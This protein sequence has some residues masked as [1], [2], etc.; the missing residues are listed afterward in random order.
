MI[1]DALWVTVFVSDSV[2]VNEPPPT[3]AFKLPAATVAVGLSQ[4]ES[5]LL[6]EEIELRFPPLEG[7]LV[8][9]F[10]SGP[11]I[12]PNAGSPAKFE[13]AAVDPEDEKV[14]APVPALRVPWA[15]S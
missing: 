2:D 1:P 8:H 13:L 7:Q 9:E 5:F 4:L 15:L 10:D 11:L 3:Y 12:S 14:C 6:S